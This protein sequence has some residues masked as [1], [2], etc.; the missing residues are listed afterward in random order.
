MKEHVRI[1]GI[2]HIIFGFFGIGIAMMIWL[3][4]A[5]IAI[6]SGDAD[7]F[8]PLMII[9][10]VV[11]GFIALISAPGILTGY[12]L[13][14]HR[15]WARIAA[16]ILGALLLMKPPLGTL[17]GIYTLWVMFHHETPGIFDL[18]QEIPLGEIA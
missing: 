2:L 7:V 16:A 8:L 14:K 10:P 12:G 6:F 13:L 17:L 9:G 5:G 4:F 3:L 1:L 15:P 18:E 11:S